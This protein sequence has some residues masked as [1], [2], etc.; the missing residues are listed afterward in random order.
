MAFPQDRL[1]TELVVKLGGVWTDITQYLYAR[2]GSGVNISYG[3]AN[4][5]SQVD[6]GQM[7]F[8][9]DNRDGR[10]TTKNPTSPYYRQFGRGTPVRFSVFA[11]DP[12]LDVPATGATST[13][14]AA[15]L[16]IV[17]DIDVRLE[18]QL[19]QDWL[20][21]Y[22]TPNVISDTLEMIGKHSGSTQK[23]WFLGL[24]DS[25][26]FFE[27]SEDGSATLDSTATEYLR[28]GPTERIAIRVTLDVNNG[29]S[30][31]TTT[32]Y[33]SDN[34][35]SST[36]TQLGD[37]VVRA[38]TTSIFSSTASLE[39]GNATD[40][41]FRVMDGKVY[42]A[43]VRDGIGGTVVANPDFSA[44]ATGTTS[45]ADSAGRTWTVPAAHEITDRNIR[46]EGRIVQVPTRWQT[47]SRDAHVQFTAAGPLRRIG[48][49]QSPLAS[50]LFREY[51]NP[52]RAGTGI[53]DYWPMEEGT[54]AT[55]FENAVAGRGPM[56]YSGDVHLS[57]LDTYAPS[58]ALPE[59]GAGTAIGRVARYPSSTGV[60]MR[61][62]VQLSS[63][64][65]SAE[66]T[67]LA[68]ECTGTIRKAIVR[69]NT[70][71]QLAVNL[72]DENNAV[73]VGT[74]F[75]TYFAAGVPT[76]ILL[77]LEQVGADVDVNMRVYD[78]RGSV[79]DLPEAGTGFL[80]TTD[81][82]GRVTKCRVGAESDLAGISVGHVVFIN[83]LA[84]FTNTGNAMVGWKGENDLNRFRRISY[85]EEQDVKTFPGIFTA[86]DTNHAMG[87]QGELTFL[88]LLRESEEVSGGILYEDRESGALILRDA[89]GLYSQAARFTLD[90]N[91]DDGLVTPLDPD[92][93]DQELVN[94]MTANQVSGSS[95]RY[96]KTSG[97]LNI[98]D[99]EDDPEG[100]GPY[101]SSVDLDVWRGDQL[102]SHASWRVHLGTWD[103]WRFPR[104]T[105]YLQ[106]A[107]HMIDEVSRISPGDVFEIVDMPDFTPPDDARLMAVGYSEFVSQFQWEITLN[108]QP[109]R[110]WDVGVLDDDELGRADTDGSV[111][112]E[113]L[114]TTETD[115]DVFVES[116]PRWIDSDSFST[117]FPFDI[118]MAGERAT[119]TAINPPIEDAFGRTETDTWGAADSGQTWVLT[120][121][122]ADFDVLSG[123][124]RVTHPATGISKL[125]LIA[126]PYDDIDMYMDVATDVLAAGASIFAGP[127]IRA[128]DNN[129]HYAVRLD[130]TTGAAVNLTIRKRVAGVETQLASFTS[131][132]THV[133][134]TFYRVR[135]QVIGSSLKAK[136]WNPASSPEPDTWNATATDT[137]IT[138]TASIGM[139]S[140]RNTGNTN[141]NAQIRFDNVQIINPQRFT[142]TRSVNGV[143]KAQAAGEDVNL[144]VPF[145]VGL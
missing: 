33:Y 27:W 7:T 30:G 38:G 82:F 130:F 94:D 99:P 5:G 80:Q 112:A 95:V 65:P 118:K 21:T 72:Y 29:A 93:D 123:Y 104:V 73:I 120:G 69:V 113:A 144:A 96:Q 81:T 91:G 43:Q 16:D 108:C 111:L 24:R 66:R 64:P 110:P 34:I 48:Q 8:E 3:R 70:S 2:S 68:M 106:G 128:T 124:G 15:A 32:F 87:S 116:G 19:D 36:W 75:D 141:A 17:G 109:A 84:A 60:G 115:A 20:V 9:L 39:I 79:F 53:T 117:Q 127:L 56:S 55:Q 129:N 98:S 49:G 58:L 59:F 71:N 10:F 122:A 105:V 26:L 101:E 136:L 11:G 23:S 22:N 28:V 132:I 134:T 119:V 114:T 61:A 83:D 44:Q 6:P 50:A 85:E 1:D 92:E 57:S 103:E 67:L 107:T 137:D 145:I 133:A 78:C 100:V 41:S 62:F 121:T 143:V 13:P 54:E 86:S 138:A 35:N 18:L 135:F 25:R 90:Y 31:N 74:A 88:G 142:L 42:K 77:T 4:E 139:R 125:S 126:A 51:T 131:G 76:Q 140:F 97:S 46:F 37:P 52:A 45:F 89:A 12:Y 40:F 14:D 47:G 63:T 102:G